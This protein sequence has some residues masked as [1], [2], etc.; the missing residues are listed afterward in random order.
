MGKNY[1]LEI[2]TIIA[3]VKGEH[4]GRIGNVHQRGIDTPNSKN[5]DEVMIMFDDDC[6]PPWVW[7]KIDECQKL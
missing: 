3:V 2:D 7:L 6:F 4:K 5:K 1:V